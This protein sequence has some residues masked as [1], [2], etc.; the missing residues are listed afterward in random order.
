MNADFYIRTIPSYENIFKSQILRLIELQDKLD[1][2]EIPRYRTAAIFDLLILQIQQ[3]IDQNDLYSALESQ[4][5]NN[6]Y[7]WQEE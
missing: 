5:A 7:V 6:K 2:L 1:Q 4:Y 3:A